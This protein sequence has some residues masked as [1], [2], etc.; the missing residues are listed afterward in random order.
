MMSAGAGNVD[1]QRLKPAPVTVFAGTADHFLVQNNQRFD[2]VFIDP[3]FE[4]RLQW[5]ML[6][7]LVPIHLTNS[8]LIYIESPVNWPIP[9]KLPIGCYVHKEKQFGDVYAR[10]LRF[11]SV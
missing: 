2:V 8:A 11:S 10:L 4:S 6:E 1:D 9:E 3:P 5:A 7:Q